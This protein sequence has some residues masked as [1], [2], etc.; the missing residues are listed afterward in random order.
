MNQKYLLSFCLIVLSFNVLPAQDNGS[1]KTVAIVEPYT[2]RPNPRTEA[3]ILNEL[4]SS[5][6]KRELTSYTINNDSIP[7]ENWRSVLVSN[8]WKRSMI[9]DQEFDALLVLRNRFVTGSKVDWLNSPMN[10]YVPSN[11]I[12]KSY[13]HPQVE[14]ILY[15]ESGEV[16]DKIVRKTKGKDP[17]KAM[18]KVI[19]RESERILGSLD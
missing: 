6:S 3:L 1:K 17:I 16:I 5:V 10:E 19:R 8:P 13:V 11:V 15:D 18:Q 12:Y 4:A 9:L 7:F 2:D 14:M